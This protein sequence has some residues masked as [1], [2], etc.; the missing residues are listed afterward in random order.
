MFMLGVEIAQASGGGAFGMTE[1]ICADERR[2]LDRLG[3]FFDVNPRLLF[4]WTHR[5]SR[6]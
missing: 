1:R 6:V 2:A 3:L 5:A 4:S